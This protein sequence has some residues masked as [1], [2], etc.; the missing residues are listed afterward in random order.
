MLRVLKLRTSNFLCSPFLFPIM[1]T[2][3]SGL[4]LSPNPSLKDLTLLKA[5][6]LDTALAQQCAVKLHNTAGVIVGQC[7]QEKSIESIATTCYG[8]DP[9]Y[10]SQPWT[11]NSHRA[12]IYLTSILQWSN[13]EVL[14]EPLRWES[15][16]YILQLV[17]LYLKAVFGYLK[18]TSVWTMWTRWSLR[19][20]TA[21]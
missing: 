6:L 12:K 2:Y 8:L 17:L 16:Y 18:L 9:L 4:G 1:S 20:C 13:C 11:R 15:D 14:W 21:A 10:E 5:H 7:Q 19:S 3:L